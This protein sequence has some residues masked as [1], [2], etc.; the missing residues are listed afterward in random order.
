[1]KKNKNL[2]YLIGM[3]GSGKTYF[4]KKLANIFG[5]EFIDLDFYIEDK[6]NKTIDEIISET[7]ER[8]FRNI[9]RKHLMTLALDKIINESK[10]IIS[11]GGGTPCYMDNID[12]MKRSGEVIYLD[13]PFFKIYKRCLKSNERPL[14]KNKFTLFF[15][16]L[17][18]KKRRLQYYLQADTII[19]L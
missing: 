6:E 14:L 8:Y 1:M 5:Y 11:C 10:T 13:T 19:K 4:G 18:I 15:K 17:K 2:I 3:P 7:S 12:L 9:E 16:L